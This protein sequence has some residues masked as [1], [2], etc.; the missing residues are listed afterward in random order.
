MMFKKFIILLWFPYNI[1]Y[2]LFKLW[3]LL[4]RLQL[5]LCLIVSIEFSFI[6][7]TYRDIDKILNL[8]IKFLD[9]CLF[10]GLRL[11][12]W[13]FNGVNSLFIMVEIY[14]RRSVFNFSFF[15]KD[16][17]SISV[18]RDYGLGLF[19]ES[20]LFCFWRMVWGVF[21][22]TFLWIILKSVSLG[23]LCII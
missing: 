6:Y 12:K 1:F 13:P 14:F 3:N 8:N 17:F 18:G 4:Y 20:S 23:L 11:P 5:L 9:E 21:V 22:F 15:I 10:W 16:T 7:W 19:L 2:G